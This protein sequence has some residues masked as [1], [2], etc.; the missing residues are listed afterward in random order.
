MLRYLDAQGQLA[1]AATIADVPVEARGEVVVVDATL[2]PEA[3]GSA[4]WVHLA[5]LRQAQEDGAYP[6]RV[7][8]RAVFEAR[9]RTK[10]VAAG[11]AV[12]MYSTAWC[13]VCKK[14]RK[15]L[16]KLGVSFVEKDIEKDPGAAAELQ[17]KASK[18]GVKTSGV[19]VFDVGGV[20][21][22]GFDEGK[23]RKLLAAG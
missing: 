19:P 6:V 21:L 5:D 14:A 7:V 13:G 9:L 12:T 20:I 8:A 3:R 16:T 18:A 15:F 10:A 17:R 22:P 1:P 11:P 23:L 2:A 4:D